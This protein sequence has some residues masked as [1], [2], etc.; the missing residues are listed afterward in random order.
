MHIQPM[1]NS[2]PDVRGDVNDSLVRAIEA[3]Y[4]CAAVCRICADACLAEKIVADLTQ[5][6]RLNLDCADV[7][8]VTGGLAARRAGGNEALI[9]R[10]L[11][12]CAQACADCAAECDK[13]ADKHEHC[14]LCADECCRCE[15][16]CR[17]AAV[18]ITASRH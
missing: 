2:H 14:R 1:I 17:E 8:L 4:G 16:A 11:E 13:H 7:C 10:M 15:E 6:I 3:A 9:K 12:A 18:T 5:C